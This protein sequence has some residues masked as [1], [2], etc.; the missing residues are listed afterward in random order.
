MVQLRDQAARGL[1]TVALLKTFFDSGHDHIGMF[2][3]FVIDV[4]AAHPTEDFAVTD[5]KEGLYS[6]HGLD[7]PIPALQTLL[8]RAAK[9]WPIRREGGRY[10]K[11]ATDSWGP[12]LIKER[13][14]IEREHA[15]VASNLIDFGSRRGFVF[16]AEEEALA[17]L[18]T[19]LEENHVTMLV[20]AGPDK[21]EF[22]SSSLSRRTFVLIAH[23]IKESF[24]SDPNTANYIMRMLEGLV[25]QNTLLLR[26]IGQIGQKFTN[27]K[28]FLDTRF[29]LH[30]LGYAGDAAKLAARET[31]DLLKATNASLMVFE[32]TIDEV[33]RILSVY[34]HRLGTPSGI[35]SLRP[36]EVTRHLVMYHYSPSDIVQAISLLEHN[37]RQLG[38]SIRPFPQ[39]DPGH[40][41]AEETLS[42]RLQKLGETEMAERVMHDV[43]CTAGILTF[44]AGHYSHSVEGV[45]AVFATSSASVVKTVTDWYRENEGLGIPPVVHIIALSNVGWLKRPKMAGRLKQNELTA[46]CSAALRPSEVAWNAFIRTLKKLHESGE[47][48]SDECVAIVV[49]G[50]ADQTITELQEDT[51]PDPDTI[52]EVIFRVRESYQKKA[53]V[54]VEKATSL[55]QEHEAK[56]KKREEEM[57]QLEMNVYRRSEDIAGWVTN[58]GFWALAVMIGFGLFVAAGLVPTDPWWARPAWA[59]CSLVVIGITFF[60]LVWGS[61]LN[62]LRQVTRIGFSKTIRSWLMD[63][64]KD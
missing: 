59:I 39:R 27:L 21:P 31:I 55:A 16:Q 50:L 45:R 7:V 57:R 22:S 36:T 58:I 9:K 61:T 10:L 11:S 41:L 62:E 12:D 47:L 53:A 17:L 5:I 46:L 18:M 26:D 25:L 19:F 6:R 8:S 30:A 14:V 34:Q 2:L 33:K 35:A 24:R 60:N 20:V 52:S 43:D 28:V 64:K 37:I 1:A 13:A 51:E 54:D 63:A 40:T 4:I 15:A 44:R 29:L 48:N 49:K 32:R 42:H 23:F 3:P 56:A 38:M